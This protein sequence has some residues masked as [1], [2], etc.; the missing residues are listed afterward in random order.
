M[1]QEQEILTMPHDELEAIQLEGIKKT[2][3]S[4]INLYLT[5]DES[6]LPQK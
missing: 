6:K 1:K 2:L 3:G 5:L 4:A